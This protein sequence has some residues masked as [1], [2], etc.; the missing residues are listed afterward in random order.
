MNGGYQALGRSQVLKAPFSEDSS[1][2]NG[3]GR[4]LVPFSSAFLVGNPDPK[5][6]TPKP[7][8]LTLKP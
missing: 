7:L 6:L 2:G 4:G 5:T 3:G 8:T 1:E